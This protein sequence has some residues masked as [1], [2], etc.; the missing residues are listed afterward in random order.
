[1]ALLPL[2][3]F[4]KRKNKVIFN[5]VLILCN[6]HWMTPPCVS[7]EMLLRLHVSAVITD[8]IIENGNY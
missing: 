5:T 6:E 1:M 7:E 8:N 2:G 3:T 4:F